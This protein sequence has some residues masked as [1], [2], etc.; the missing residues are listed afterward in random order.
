MGV[1]MDEKMAPVVYVHCLAK[2]MG[3]EGTEI[4]DGLL[5]EGKEA[6]RLI[7]EIFK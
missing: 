7:R 3:S 5:P 4:P 6:E 1:S 2:A